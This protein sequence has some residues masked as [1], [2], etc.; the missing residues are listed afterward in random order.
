FQDQTDSRGTRPMTQAT[1]DVLGVGNAIVDIL[2]QADD[3]F[4]AKHDMPKGG[5][6]LVDEAQAHAIYEAMGSGV[7]ASG[8]SAANSIAGVASFGGKA[9]F[10]GRVRDD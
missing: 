8:G 9:A 3:A 2:T 1:H 7:E 5:M 10:I 4:L 6:A